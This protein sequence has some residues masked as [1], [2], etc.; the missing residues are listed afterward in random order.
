MS[1]TILDKINQQRRTD[2]DAAK[3]VVSLEEIRKQ[4][5]ASPFPVVSLVDRLRLNAGVA[6]MA[7]VKRASPSKGDI[8]PNIDAAAQGL[9]Y[10]KAGAAA[11]SCLTEPHWFKGTLDDMKGIRMGMYFAVQTATIIFP[12]TFRCVFGEQGIGV[13][14]YYKVSDV[15]VAVMKRSTDYQN[16]QHYYERTS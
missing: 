8:A 1:S 6:V 7:E 5:L 3:Q 11:I 10:A 12:Q 13:Q 9:T 15:N 16:V 4:A 14:N 2:V